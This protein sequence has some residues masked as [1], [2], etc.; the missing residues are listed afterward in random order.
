[1]LTVVF[2]LLA[3]ICGTLMQNVY[4]SALALTLLLWGEMAAQVLC[5][6]AKL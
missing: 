6:Q 3:A 1:M 2:T 4:L 5:V